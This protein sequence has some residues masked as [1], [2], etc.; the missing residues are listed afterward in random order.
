MKNGAKKGIMI[1]TY[2]C[3]VISAPN[4]SC[5][6]CWIVRLPQQFGTSLLRNLNGASFT[7]LDLVSG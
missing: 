2:A 4:Q 1:Q 3:Y 7:T 5:I 6:C